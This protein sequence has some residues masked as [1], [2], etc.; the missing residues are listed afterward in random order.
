MD[1]V[2]FTQILC[3]VDFSEFSRHALDHAAALARRYEGRLTVLSVLPNLPVMDLPPL[4]MADKDRERLTDELKRF[5]THLTP[6]LPIDLRLHEAPDVHY[7]ILAQAAALHADLLVVGSHGRSGFERLLLGSVTEKLLRKAP[8]PLMVVPRRAPDTPPDAPLQ[9]HRILCP[10][11][12][13]AGSIRALTY[14]TTLALDAAAQLTVVHVIEVPPELQETP[15]SAAFSVDSVR[16]AAEAD[17]LRRL[18]ELIPQQ[19]MSTNAVETSVL[20]GAAHR[21]ILKA[22]GERK[23]DLIV[24][25]VQG[26]GAVDLMVFGSNT[27]RVARAATCPVMVVRAS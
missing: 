22:A 3:P 21:E 5:T 9:F 26:R 20:E 4:A 11:D 23:S 7:E 18:R 27:A 25:G 16:A 24:M 19:A 13:S 10:V 8:C 12:F 17:R 15:V 1:R 6:E 2:R 14:A